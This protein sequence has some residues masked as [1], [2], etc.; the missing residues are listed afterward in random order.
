MKKF[1]KL[2]L[3]ILIIVVCCICLSPAFAAACASF[4]TTAGFPTLASL[5]LTVGENVAWYVAGAAALG[6]GYLINPE[7]TSELVQDIADVA[8]KVGGAVVDVVSGV[9]SGALSAFVSSPFG[10]LAIGAGLWFLF[11]RDD[12]D[13][14]ETV[15]APDSQP[16]TGSQGEV[17]DGA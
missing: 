2:L 9:A 3:F 6:L 5:I 10:L 17:P 7:G 16:M 12:N 1:F 4:F 13:K 8:S 14:S 15:A 11:S